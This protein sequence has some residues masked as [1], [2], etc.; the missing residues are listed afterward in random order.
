M[1]KKLII[2]GILKNRRG[3]SKVIKEVQAKI[4]S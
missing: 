2:T 3:K 4:I 1:I